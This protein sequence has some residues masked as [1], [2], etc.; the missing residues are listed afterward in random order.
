[1]FQFPYDAFDG[2]RKLG[3]SFFLLGSYQPV[4]KGTRHPIFIYLAFPGRRNVRNAFELWGFRGGKL[5]VG[6]AWGNPV[7]GF[8]FDSA[9]RASVAP[10]VLSASV[11]SK[12][13]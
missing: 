4:I 2:S 5:H 8:G 6:H 10:S 12:A 3:R 9:L 13:G 7:A 1:M 11:S